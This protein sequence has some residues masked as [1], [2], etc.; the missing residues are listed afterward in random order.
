[1][2]LSMYTE[3]DSNIIRLIICNKHVFSPIYR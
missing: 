3:R 2:Y 1:M